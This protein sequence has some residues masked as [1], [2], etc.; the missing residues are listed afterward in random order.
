MGQ[1]RAITAVAL[2]MAWMPVGVAVRNGLDLVPPMGWSNWENSGWFV[3]RKFTIICLPLCFA[4][5]D[6]PCR[7]N[8][9]ETYMKANAQAL[10]DKGGVANAYQ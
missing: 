5:Q 4:Q 10:K 9:N 8:I 2:A 3:S 7:S 6:T 1:L